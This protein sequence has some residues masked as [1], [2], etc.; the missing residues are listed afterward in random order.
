MKSLT[1]DQF[2]TQLA[3]MLRDIPYG[4]SADLTGYAIAF[5]NG[6]K[7]IYAFVSSDDSGIIED[8]FELS[9]YEWDHWHDEFVTWINEPIFSVRPELH[10]RTYAVSAGNGAR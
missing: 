10:K 6:S 2:K 7:V 3:S 1:L 9:D 8:E 5:W 4:T